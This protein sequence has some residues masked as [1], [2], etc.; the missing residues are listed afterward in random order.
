MDHFLGYFVQ[1]IS[2]HPSWT[3]AVLCGVSFGESLPILS[4]LFPGTAL[5]LAAGTVVPTS[6]LAIAPAVIGAIVGAVLGD[7]VAYWLGRRFG[8]AIRDIWPF[9]RHPDL[10][11]RGIAYFQR[12]GGLSV[13]IGRFFGPLRA[14]VPL[15]A[16]ILEMR[17]GRFWFANITSAIIWAPGLLL[18]G[19]IATTVLRKLGLGNE[20]IPV[21]IVLLVVLGFAVSWAVVSRGSRRDR[22]SRDNQP[23]N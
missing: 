4:L 3:A 18:P 8:H 17:A 1:F 14:I 20:A 19:T 22:A 13:F 7:G 6:G 2:D 5:L 21:A 12:Y 15:A 10:V 23:P 9:T 16:G 11:P